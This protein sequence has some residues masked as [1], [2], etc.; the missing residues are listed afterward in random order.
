MDMEAP[1]DA[2]YVW[3]GVAA[4][5]A[6]LAGIAVQLPSDAP[7]DANEAANTIDEVAASTTQSV[8]AYDHGAKEVKLETDRISMRND[9]G[10]TRSSIVFGPLTPIH[11]VSDDE[12]RAALDRILDGEQ[13]P[14]VIADSRTLD[15]ET[16][17]LDA[18]EAAR[19]EHRAGGAEWR[20]AAG[21][22]R[23]RSLTLDGKRVVI[24]DA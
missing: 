6:A 21:E 14:D 18:A 23:V 24:L 9:G 20:P 5:S 4:V 22:L 8:A 12:T 2:W 11:A 10:T 13:P 15:S 17:L 1:V 7:P 19:T 3:I 16:E